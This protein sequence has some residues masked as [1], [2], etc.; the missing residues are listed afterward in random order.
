MTVEL[1]LDFNFSKQLHRNLI[2]PVN[3]KCQVSCRGPSRPASRLEFALYLEF[4]VGVLKIEICWVSIAQLI[5]C[6][7]MEFGKVVV[8]FVCA[9]AALSVAA[10]TLSK[11]DKKTKSKDKKEVNFQQ[12]HPLLI[13]CTTSAAVY[14]SLMLYFFEVNI[15]FL[16][17]HVK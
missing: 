15:N 17:V 16:N 14:K 4:E 5:A 7:G 12:T 11:R 6:C 9:L 10:A 3:G 8:A 2:L 13:Q 1:A